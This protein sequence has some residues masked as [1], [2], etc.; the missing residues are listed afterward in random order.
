MNPIWPRLK[1]QK[2]LISM[3]RAG[4]TTQQL[5]C[6]NVRVELSQAF[7]NAEIGFAKAFIA[8]G[9]TIDITPKMRIT[10]SQF[11]RKRDNCEF[12]NSDVKHRSDESDRHPINLYPGRS[13]RSFFQRKAVRTQNVLV[14]SGKFFL[15]LFGQCHPLKR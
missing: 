7:T 11:M 5:H 4:C 2:T 12:L 10:V 15:D 13:D 9:S 14:N 6:H 1:L 3:M 8:P